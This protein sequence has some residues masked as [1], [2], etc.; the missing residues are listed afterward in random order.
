MTSQPTPPKVSPQEIAGMIRASENPLVSLD[1]AGPE[2]QIS[3]G[4]I[5]KKGG[6]PGLTSHHAM[7]H[8]IF[9]SKML[10]R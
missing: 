4:G 3:D 5:R 2:T 1:K 7:D 9:M 8:E 6:G 10:T